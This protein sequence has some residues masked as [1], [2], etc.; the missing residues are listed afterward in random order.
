MQGDLA[1]TGDPQ[2]DQLNNTNPLALLISML[3]DQ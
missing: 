3:L 1:V 2:A